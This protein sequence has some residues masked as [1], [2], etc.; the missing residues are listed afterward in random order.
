MTTKRFVIALC[1]WLF[2][3]SSF[4]ASI[5]TKDIKYTVG[6]SY[7][8]SFDYDADYRSS[9][10]SMDG[11]SNGEYSAELKPGFNISA[12]VRWLRKNA[13]G[14]ILGIT[15]MSK[16]DFD[17]VTYK[18]DTGDELVDDDPGYSVSAAAFDF[19]AAYRFEK[20]YIPL[21]VN[22]STIQYDGNSDY[23]HYEYGGIGAT[24]G[25]GYE[26]S[27]HLVLE[28]LYRAIKADIVAATKDDNDRMQLVHGG[29]LRDL[30]F[31]V[32]YQF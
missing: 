32:K 26:A 9:V 23:E 25:I 29:V 2:I 11:Y 15:Y 1:C 8:L 12:D 18:A 16:R 28:I 24:F 27:P 13:F 14:A 10:N 19:L 30:S 21:G 6:G 5:D 22:F 4:A 31:G 17:K 3:G 7:S 20:L